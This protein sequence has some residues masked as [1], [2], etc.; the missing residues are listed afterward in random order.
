MKDR[1]EAETP[2]EVVPEPKF[3]PLPEW[4]APSTRLVHGARRPERNA[5]AVVP[6]I[7][8]TSTYHYPREFSEARESGAVHLYT[9]HSNP[10]HEVAAELVRDLEGA[11]TARVF[12]SGM[13]A[14]T[15]T[16]LTFVHAGDEVVALE[17]LYGGTIELLTHLLPRL[18]VRVRWV[19]DAQ[20][21]RPEECVSATTRLV[22][23]ESPTN[24]LLRVYDLR[25]WASAADRVGALTVVDNTFATP[26]NQ[27]PLDL[28]VDLAVHSATKYLGGHADLVAGA[29]AG[30]K[31]LIDRIDS[32]HSVVGSVLDPIG[33]FLLARGMRTLALRVHRQNLNGAAVA[34]ALRGHPAVGAVHYPGSGDAD[35]ESIA[36]RQMRGRGGMVSVVLQGGRT[37][38]QAWLRRLRF[39]H[40]A[41]SLGGVESLASIPS[42]T[43]HRHLS[44]DELLRRGIEPGLVRLSLGI[45]ES[46]DLVRDLTEGLDA[47]DVR[48]GPTSL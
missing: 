35:Q 44:D 26:I 20:A 38:A 15:S 39:V 47:L 25:R 46:A 21:R 3:D 32:T 5:G 34:S 22:L 17:N 33:A 13:G 4:T 24:P 6:P 10:T 41:S 48:A 36:Q 11:Q 7:Y 42:E 45:E 40:T 43:S 37:A 23:L 18:G 14:I 1:K 27:R 12:G 30:P 9:R 31:A 8:Q 16:V 19:T 29:V 28:G 2:R